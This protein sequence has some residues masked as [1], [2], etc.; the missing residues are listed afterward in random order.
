MAEPIVL[1]IVGIKN[2]GLYDANTNYEK[3]NVVTYQGSTYCALQDCKGKLPTNTDYWQLYAEK[4]STGDTGPQGPKPVKGVDYYTA[5]DKAEIEADLEEVIPDVVSDVVSESIGSLT[6]ATPLAASDISGMTDTTR[7]YVNTTDGHWYW[8]DGDSWEDGGVYQGVVLED[9]SVIYSKLSSDL[10]NSL[11]AN[12][13]TTNNYL[14]NKTDDAYLNGLDG[15]VE[16]A[17]GYRYYSITCEYGETYKLHDYIPS[18]HYPDYMNFIYIKNSDGEVIYKRLIR[19]DTRENNY[20]DTYVTIPKGGVTLQI[21]TITEKNIGINKVENYIQKEKISYNQLDENLQDIFSV[22]A[23]NIT[24][25]MITVVDG[26]FFTGSSFVQASGYSTKQIDVTPGKKYKIESYEF[27]QRNILFFANHNSTITLSAGDVSYTLDN[28][29]K[30]YKNETAGEFT[31]EFVCPP[32]YNKVY[33]SQDNAHP[34]KVYEYSTYKIDYNIK[35][36]LYGKKY[37]ACGDSFTHGDFTGYSGD[38]ADIYDSTLQMYKTYPYWIGTRNNMTVINEAINGSIMALD[39]T[40]V[41]D[42]SGVS[43]NT[44]YPFSYQRYQEIPSD[45]DYITIMFGLNDMFNTY[46]GTINDNTNTSFYGAGNVVLQWLITNRPDAKIGIIISNSYLSNNYRQALKELSAKWGVGYLD[47]YS[48][49]SISKTLNGQGMSETA[50]AIRNAQYYVTENNHHPNVK[51]HIIMSH[52]IED[53][54][55]KL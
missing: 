42:P 51:A 49:T 27:Y 47:L 4:G 9:K 50:Q 36:I 2:M 29:V 22:E 24:S 34:T 30:L 23:K 20:I 28:Y 16:A 5:S 17:N 13:D 40:Y 35:D 54:L 1:G 52:A 15:H 26:Y 37:V 11:E 10:K 8:Y 48:D 31:Y 43:I 19:E 33:I 44:R 21:N 6:S 53:F 55:R 14:N 32:Y 7:I 39:K 3:L 38:Q 45:A 41:D 46:L 12:F 25:D 18:S